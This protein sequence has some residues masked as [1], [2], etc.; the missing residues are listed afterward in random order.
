MLYKEHKQAHFKSPCTY[1]ISNLFNVFIFRGKITCSTK[2]IGTLCKA[3]KCNERKL[4]KNV[5]WY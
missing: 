5:S 1:T 2:D 3:S 4:I